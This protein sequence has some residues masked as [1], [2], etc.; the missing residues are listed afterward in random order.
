MCFLGCTAWI[1]L[2]FIQIVMNRIII[3]SA[4]SI[5]AFTEIPFAGDK[6]EAYYGLYNP[7]RFRAQGVMLIVNQMYE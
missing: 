7:V 6:R 3:E 5:V 4:A 2:G 1:L